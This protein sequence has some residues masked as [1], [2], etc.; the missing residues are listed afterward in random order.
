MS[1]CPSTSRQ[2]CLRQVCAV[3]LLAFL[4]CW[5]SNSRFVVCAACAAIH[6]AVSSF[7]EISHQRRAGWVSYFLSVMV[8]LT[9]LAATIAVS[10]SPLA[11]PS[12]LALIVQLSLMVGLDN[13]KYSA[14]FLLWLGSA[15]VVIL[16]MFFI[17]TCSLLHSERHLEAGLLMPRVLWFTL[18]VNACAV[19]CLLQP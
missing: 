7:V 9:F 18:C 10:H 14:I 4:L 16:I 1:G 12:S 19:P 5:E 2:Y 15:F 6:F 8:F 3:F 13:L 17:V 11:I